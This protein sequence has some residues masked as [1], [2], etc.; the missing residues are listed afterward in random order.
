MFEFVAPI[1]KRW[2]Q[3][4]EELIKWEEFGKLAKGGFLEDIVV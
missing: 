3:I 2:N 4:V 1:R